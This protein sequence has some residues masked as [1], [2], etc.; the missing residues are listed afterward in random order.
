M[1]L[2]S[3]IIGGSSKEQLTRLWREL[4][5]GKTDESILVKIVDQMD[6]QFFLEHYNYAK[7][8]D[9]EAARFRSSVVRHHVY[10][11]P[12]RIKDIKTKAV[13]DAFLKEFH[14]KYFN[15]GYQG[16]RILLDE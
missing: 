4:D 13:V 2:L 11:L 6:H 16:M 9:A 12:A 5:E 14:E 15:Q 8:N 1:Q 3:D 7:K 10:T